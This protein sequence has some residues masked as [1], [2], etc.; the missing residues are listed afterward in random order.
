MRN[1]ILYLFLSALSLSLLACATGVPLYSPDFSIEANHQSR[2]DKAIKTA[3]QKRR[4]TIL[5]QKPGSI[6]AKYDRGRKY[7]A[8]VKID[9]SRSNVKIN[10][11]DSVN[12]NQSQSDSG[13]MLIHK[14]YNNWI[15]YLERD[16]QFELSHM[17]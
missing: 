4:W 8:T 2:A 6:T 14:T 17:Q 12:L 9:Y 11:V 16:I 13:E 10:L 15:H 5:N 7:S 1:A 3:L